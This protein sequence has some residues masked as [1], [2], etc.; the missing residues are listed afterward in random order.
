MKV[1]LHKNH[2]ATIVFIFLGVLSISLLFADGFLQPREAMAAAI[3]CS[4]GVSG[5]HF[6]PTVK[7]GTARDVPDGRFLGSHARH[8]GYSTAASK[9]QYQYACT[10]CH[11]STSYTNNHQSGYKNITGSSLPGNRYSVGKRI[12]NTNSPAFGNCSNIY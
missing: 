9:R 12:A 11:P 8:S 4:S 1:K 6:T 7:D 10:K 5:C 2:H 3:S